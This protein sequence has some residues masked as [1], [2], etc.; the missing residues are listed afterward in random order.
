MAERQTLRD[1]V[2]VGRPEDLRLSQRPPPFRTFALEQV[3]PAAPRNNT[4][5]VPV[6]LK[7]LLT[8]FLVLMPFGRRIRVLSFN[9]RLNVHALRRG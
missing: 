5:P 7:R 9:E 1:T 8:D 4:L 6:I 3:A 2:N